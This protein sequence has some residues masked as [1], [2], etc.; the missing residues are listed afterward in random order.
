MA[1]LGDVTSQL[2]Q[3]NQTSAA[4]VHSNSALRLAIDGVSDQLHTQNQINVA[5][6]NISVAI[7]NSI[8][9]IRVMF[10]EMMLDASTARYAQLESER[11][12]LNQQKRL[13]EELQKNAD[14]NDEKKS[15]FL[16]DLFKFDALK[17]FFTGL[18]T[19][20][21]ANPIVSTILKA[22]G[23]VVAYLGAESGL[24][25]FDFKKGSAQGDIIRSLNEAV[26]DMRAAVKSLTDS[27]KMFIPKGTPKIPTELA[28]AEEGVESLS[29]LQR[30]QAVLRKWSTKMGDILKDAGAWLESSKA[31]QWMGKWLGRFAKIL[32]VKEGLDHRMEEIEGLKE[33]WEKD[34]KGAFATVG[35]TIGSFY[36]EFIN[37]LKDAPL[38]AIKKMFP[39]L[40]DKDGKFD[41]KNWFTRQLRVLN[42]I[43][44][45]SMIKL[46]FDSIANLITGNK[47][48]FKQQYEEFK[49][50]IWEATGAEQFKPD[51]VKRAEAAARRA[52]EEAA[53]RKTTAE[54]ADIQAQISATQQLLNKPEGQLPPG[55]DRHLLNLQKRQLELENRKKRLERMTQKDN[56]PLFQPHWW[57]FGK[58]GSQR[59]VKDM[60]RTDL[61]LQKVLA[62][63]KRY[64]DTLAKSKGNIVAVSNDNNSKTTVNNTTL[65]GTPVNLGST[66]NPYTQGDTQTG[67]LFGG[68]LGN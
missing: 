14:K 50:W 54:I 2:Q 59:Y 56:D 35:G 25:N 15:S 34:V 47:E 36:G 13:A 19:N 23:L 17:T 62:E 28:A 12:R 64:E 51:S 41:S 16:K 53:T 6:V 38:W 43:D 67:N 46:V 58:T 52:K 5:L 3:L 24:I 55:T 11:E 22:A 10:D 32:S 30:I 60:E 9:D 65:K 63:K 29:R 8:N 20:F 21:L 61:E 4:I 39:G 49:K 7:R 27:V 26:K 57:E 37:F 44:F 31:L 68:A 1:T 66:V 45:S 18:F 40:V 48:W 42:A 33:G